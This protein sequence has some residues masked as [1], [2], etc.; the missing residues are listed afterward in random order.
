MAI[1]SSVGVPEPDAG[2]RVEADSS[3]PGVEQSDV[4]VVDERPQHGDHHHRQ[5]HRHEEG[6]R[7]NVPPFGRA[8]SSPA[9]AIP[10]TTSSTI[11][12]AM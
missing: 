10:T 9:S 5:H 4:R 3:Q 6:H 11:V 7:K 8:A 2:Q 12:I 1:E